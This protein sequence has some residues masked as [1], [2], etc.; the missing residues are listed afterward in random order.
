MKG[1]RRFLLALFF[2]LLVS[3]QASV[4]FAEDVER[5]VTH[6]VLSARAA[7]VVHQL[8]ALHGTPQLRLRRARAAT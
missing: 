6:R 8:R 3:A 7:D 5:G 4:T 1:G 2:L